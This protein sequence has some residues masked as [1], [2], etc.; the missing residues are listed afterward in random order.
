MKNNEKINWN[1]NK[2]K[3]FYKEHGLEL[4][5]N[6][7]I[8]NRK[9]MKCRNSDGYL[10][11][12]ALS[13][14]QSGM[15]PF[16]FIKSNPYVLDNIKKFLIDNNAQLELLSDE[17]INNMSPLKLKC[18]CGKI[19][20]RPLAYVKDKKRFLC[21]KCGYKDSVD[22]QRLNFDIVKQVYKEHKLNI[23]PNQI[24]KS[25][26]KPLNC[27]TQDGYKVHISYGNLV[28]GK[29]PN[30]FSVT[31]NSENYDY[32]IKQFIK[33]NNLSCEYIKLIGHDGHGHPVLLM[34]C[35]CGDV[36]T[37]EQHDLTT[38]LRCRCLKCVGK[39]SNIEYKVKQWL[40]ENNIEFEEQKKFIECKGKKKCLPFDFYIPNINMCIEVDGQQ[41]FKD[42]HS[43]YKRNNQEEYDNMKTQYCKDN[44]IK[45]L[46]I[47]YWEF[48][49]ND[50][51]IKI[52]SNNI[53]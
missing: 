50:N 42:V 48:N 2:V 40:L 53:L 6:E 19:F 41:H 11:Q 36:F 34:K 28:K 47:P 38:R 20:Y 13:N 21:K 16:P 5:E 14:V 12:I 43:R 46:R 30:I 22:S 27:I 37:T 26:I 45:L 31:H 35:E 29:K 9:P 44:N 23:L 33:N 49:E 7:Y 39:M 17:Y 32:N 52:L 10:C 15:K 24:Y 8:N 18:R 4:L 3:E 25:N 1:I 51:Y